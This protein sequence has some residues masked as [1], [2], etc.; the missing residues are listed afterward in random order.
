[1]SDVIRLG[2]IEGEL[3]GSISD[4]GV[5]ARGEDMFDANRSVVRAQ[6]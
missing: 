6:C 3:T 2:M 1:V 5:K 4:N